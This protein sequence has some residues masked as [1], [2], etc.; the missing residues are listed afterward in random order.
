MR[1]T[2]LDDSG[3]AFTHDLGAAGIQRLGGE[4]E[5]FQSCDAFA[6]R[7]FVRFLSTEEHVLTIM[8]ECLFY[9]PWTRERLARVRRF[10]TSGDAGLEWNRR[11]FSAGTRSPVGWSRTPKRSGGRK[12]SLRGG[13]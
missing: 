5:A 12:S 11:Q 7:W 13:C 6:K 1:G 9:C 8:P 2:V 10:M 3:D 4:A